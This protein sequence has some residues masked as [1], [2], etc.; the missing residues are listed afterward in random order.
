M[1]LTTDRLGHIL[2]DAIYLTKEGR[3]FDEYVSW[4]R[5]VYGNLR[6][7]RIVTVAAGTDLTSLRPWAGYAVP[8]P[9]QYVVH[10]TPRRNQ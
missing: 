4:L 2:S 10:K 5:R 7:V 1:I 8:H 3:H 9:S 6:G